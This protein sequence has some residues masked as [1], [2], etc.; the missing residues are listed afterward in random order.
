[1]EVEISIDDKIAFVVVNKLDNTFTEK[2]DNIYKILVIVGL[3]III[4]FLLIVFKKYPYP[5]DNFSSVL[6]RYADLIIKMPR[7]PDIHNL[8]IIY[9]NSINDLISFAISY[10]AKILVYDNTFYIYNQQNCYIYKN[11]LE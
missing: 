7:E 10:N 11:F 6:K 5:K 9:L 8:N 2:G 1:M 3:S 4:I